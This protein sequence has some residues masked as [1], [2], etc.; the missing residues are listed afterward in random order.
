MKVQHALIVQNPS[1][2]NF[3]V[4]PFSN[5]AKFRGGLRVGVRALNVT[6]LFTQ[7]GKCLPIETLFGF[8]TTSNLMPLLSL[9]ILRRAY[10]TNKTNSEAIANVIDRDSRDGFQPHRP[11]EA[12]FREAKLTG[13]GPCHNDTVR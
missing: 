12:H 3:L 5:C 6:L 4:F 11:H 1:H 10:E 9:V 8:L 2:S 13:W 7:R